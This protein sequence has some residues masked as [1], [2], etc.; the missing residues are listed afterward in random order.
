MSTHLCCV[1]SLLTQ[2]IK[3]S[4]FSGFHK[5]SDPLSISINK[6]QFT[7]S[8]CCECLFF[9][10]IVTRK[11]L[12]HFIR[13]IIMYFTPSGFIDSNTMAASLFDVIYFQFEWICKEIINR[14]EMQQIV[15][16]LL[17]GCNSM[18]FHHL[19]DAWKQIVDLESLFS[20][21]RENDWV[22]T[23]KV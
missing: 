18:N 9:C 5:T 8:R 2:I 16:H 14:F 10:C 17:L 11:T 12:L 6:S 21:E 13:M 4:Y 3:T 22:R 1:T 20:F 19:S 15:D 23:F 7:V